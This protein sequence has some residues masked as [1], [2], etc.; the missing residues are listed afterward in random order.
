MK[1][2]PFLER[3]AVQLA[4]RLLLLLGFVLLALSIVDGGLRDMLWNW[5]GR[6]QEVP[7]CACG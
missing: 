1:A 3:R 7:L 5:G 6:V 4:I 2:T